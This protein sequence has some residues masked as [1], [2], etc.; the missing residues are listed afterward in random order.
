MGA[1]KQSTGHNIQAQT[2]ISKPMVRHREA[3]NCLAMFSGIFFIPYF[4]FLWL[5]Y[6]VIMWWKISILFK[7][8]HRGG[9]FLL[10]QQRL[11]ALSP[12]VHL[13]A[14]LVLF[15][16]RSLCA[17]GWEAGLGTGNMINCVSWFLSR[18]D[19][20]LMCTANLKDRCTHQRLPVLVEGKG[21][22]LTCGSGSN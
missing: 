3:T 12:P 2:S 15:A 4:L 18:R 21:D 1:G 9:L 10:L 8:T 5:Y 13:R 7:I 11:P 19:L 20:S 6:N 17:W 22:R 16:A 14:P